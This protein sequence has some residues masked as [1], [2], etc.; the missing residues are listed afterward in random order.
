[1]FTNLIE[2]GLLEHGLLTSMFSKSML[3]KSMFSKSM[4]SKPVFYTFLLLVA[5]PA[6]AYSAPQDT[7]AISRPAEKPVLP[8]YFLPFYHSMIAKPV[9]LNFP[10]DPLLSN[11]IYNDALTQRNLLTVHS[12]AQQVL[13]RLQEEQRRMQVNAGLGTAVGL[14]FWGALIEE[15]LRG[16]INFQN[17]QHNAPPPP[18]AAPPRPPELRRP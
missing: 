5:A 14:F 10:V 9:K 17:K 13:D 2:H 16:Y 15:N 1:M 11:N 7:A 4:F 18:A 12:M 6:P 3:F 8:F